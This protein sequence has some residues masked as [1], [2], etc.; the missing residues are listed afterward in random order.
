MGISIDAY[1]RNMGVL[2]RAL[3]ARSS[4]MM[5][6][7]AIIAIVALCARRRPPPSRRPQVVTWR[8]D[9]LSR[10][11]AATRSRSSARRPSSRPRSVRPCS[12]TAASDGLLIERNP[13]EGLVAVH[14]R[15]AVLADADGP[16]EQRFLHI[17]EAPP[18]IAPSS[19]CG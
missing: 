19:S 18:R 2:I 9:N 15:G 17:Q 6:R 16:V 8:L 7:L 4:D 3:D 13:L 14:D 1:I 10:A 12:S 5:R 11:S